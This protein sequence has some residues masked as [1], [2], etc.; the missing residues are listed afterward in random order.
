MSTPKLGSSVWS[1]WSGCILDKEP[2]KYRISANGNHA[3]KSEIQTETAFDDITVRVSLNWRI[4]DLGNLALRRNRQKKEME[5]PRAMSA[6]GGELASRRQ[7][8]S[9]PHD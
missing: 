3:L 1:R 2:N 7:R 4:A 6:P 8:G 5:D 9:N